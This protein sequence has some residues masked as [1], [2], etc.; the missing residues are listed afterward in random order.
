MFST[1][2]IFTMPSWDPIIRNEIRR[3]IH[4]HTY[5]PEIKKL[6]HSEWT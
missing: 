5:I 6:F 3:V 4:F 2:T 1:I